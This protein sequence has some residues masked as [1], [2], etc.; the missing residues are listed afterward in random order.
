MGHQTQDVDNREIRKMLRRAGAVSGASLS[1]SK[2]HPTEWESTPSFW[3]LLSVDIR[4]DIRSLSGETRSLFLMLA[5][6]VVTISFRAPFSA[7]REVWQ[8]SSFWA[9]LFG[10]SLLFGISS[11]FTVLLV[12]NGRIK[13]LCLG[14]NLMLCF[15]YFY[16]VLAVTDNILFAS[17]LGCLSAAFSVL[18]LLLS[19]N[20]RVLL[21]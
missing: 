18:A 1:R 9:Y 19:G 12:L 13:L 15:M 20:V 14:L 21:F 11:S 5:V 3:T 10:N 17:C 16:S 8:Y 6:L 4:R 2:L 7:P